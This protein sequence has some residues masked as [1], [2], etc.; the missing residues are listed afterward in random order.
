MVAYHF[1]LNFSTL[2]IVL[3]IIVHYNLVHFNIGDPSLGY[4]IEDY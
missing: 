3:L 4:D 1:Y 2:P